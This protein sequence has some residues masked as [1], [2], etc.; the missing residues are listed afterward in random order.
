[1]EEKTQNS[2]L[3]AQSYQTKDKS[4][5]KHR[6]YN[7]S[8]EVIRFLK[9]LPNE[10][11][12]WVISDQ[13]LR[14]ATSVG[15]NII[16]AKAASS[17]RDF[18]KFYEISLKSANETKYWLGLLRDATEIDKEPINKLLSE[19]TEIARMLSASIITMKGKR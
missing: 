17:K 12:F 8:I 6:S 16:E 7:F 19:I 15:A 13:L 2:E 14:S 11:V 5:L 4:E 18:I 10:K 9:E 1:M 3:K